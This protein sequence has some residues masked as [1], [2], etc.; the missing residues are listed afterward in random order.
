MPV[1]AAC[2]NRIEGPLQTYMR[3]RIAIA[4][5]TSFRMR[6]TVQLYCQKDRRRRKNAGRKLLPDIL[7]PSEVINHHR[8]LDKKII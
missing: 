1:E 4:V 3:R 5:R 8:E 6:G 7:F 2:F